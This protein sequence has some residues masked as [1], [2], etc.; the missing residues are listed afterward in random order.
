VPTIQVTP[1]HFDCQRKPGRVSS[2]VRWIRARCAP[3]RRPHAPRGTCGNCRACLR[4]QCRVCVCVLPLFVCVYS[5]LG[6]SAPRADFACNRKL[7]SCVCVQLA[8]VWFKM[9]AIVS[10]WRPGRSRAPLFVHMFGP[11][12]KRTI[13]RQFAPHCVAGCESIAGHQA[14][15][16]IN[17]GL[18]DHTY[19]QGGF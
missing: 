12:L 5:G 13:S 9:Y 7:V 8:C 3:A 16:A 6:A 10:L 19:Y 17:H 14:W 1:P 15:R 11:L 18:H 2:C 4:R